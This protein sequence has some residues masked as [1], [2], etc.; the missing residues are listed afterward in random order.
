YVVVI[1][2]ICQGKTKGGASRDRR[3]PSPRRACPT[4]HHPHPVAGTIEFEHGQIVAKIGKRH[5]CS[6]RIIS[7]ERCFAHSQRA[8]NDCE[9]ELAPVAEGFTAGR[10]D[11]GLCAL[12][13]NCVPFWGWQR[14]ANVS[15]RQDVSE[16][17]EGIWQDGTNHYLASTLTVP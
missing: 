15:A 7:P 13:A 14:L 12:S 8:A 10:C 2:T 11:I 16:A 1:G 9:N 4:P 6:E 3:N 5:C 17:A